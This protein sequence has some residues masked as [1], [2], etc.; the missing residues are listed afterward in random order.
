MY[1]CQIPGSW[2]G[3]QSQTLLTVHQHQSTMDLGGY[4]Q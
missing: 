4:A 2:T 3:Q 1:F